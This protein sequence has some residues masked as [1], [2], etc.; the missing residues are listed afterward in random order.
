MGRPGRS[1]WSIHIS[2]SIPESGARRSDGL[3]KRGSLKT[4]PVQPFASK[5]WDYSIPVHLKRKRGLPRL[6]RRRTLGSM[7]AVAHGPTMFAFVLYAPC[8]W[9]RRYIY[10]RRL[11]RTKRFVSN[12][13][14]VGWEP[15]QEEN[16]TDGKNVSLLAAPPFPT[17]FSSARRSN[18]GQHIHIGK[19]N[20][21]A[22]AKTFASIQT[23]NHT[24]TMTTTT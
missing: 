11:T 15:Q 1:M 9:L 23:H 19:A 6:D 4:E 24:Y 18:D 20:K 22:T 5:T 12:I 10:S 14:D 8:T 7:M 17:F 21:L 13:R 2:L 3:A 16:Y